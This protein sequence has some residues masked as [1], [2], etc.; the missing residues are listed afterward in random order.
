MKFCLWV[1]PKRSLEL[2]DEIRML[3][4]MEYPTWHPTLTTE[5]LEPLCRE[6]VEFFDYD[7]NHPSIDPILMF[8]DTHDLTTVKMHGLVFE[9]RVGKGHL[10]VSA[11]RHAGRENAAGRWLLHTLIDHLHSSATP[12]N[13]LPHDVIP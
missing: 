13:A 2:A 11:V 5:F 1:P 3:T 6:F 4:W 10:L 7:R 12:K 8:W 9:T